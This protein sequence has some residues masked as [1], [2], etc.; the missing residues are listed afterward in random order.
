VTTVTAPQTIGALRRAVAAKLVEAFAAAGRHGTPALDAKVLTAHALGSDSS[1]IVLLDV[2]P[3]GEGLRECL[4]RLVARRIAGEP[5]ARIVGRKEFW[6][7][8]L[9]LSPETLVPR[10]DTETLVTAALE[11]IDRAGRRNDRLAILDLGTGTGA[12]L[13]ALLS[14]LPSAHGIG[15]DRAA[16]AV[17]MARHNAARLGF[18]ERATFAVMDWGKALAGGFDAILANPPYIEA[19]AI[20]K[21]PVEVC[22]DPLLALDGGSDG[23]DAYRAILAD[24]DRLLAGNGHA[25]LEVGA[26]QATM[27]SAIAARHGF[28]ARRHLDL[29]GI[30][31]VVELVRGSD[32]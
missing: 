5:V 26:G 17:A 13:L 18:A 9:A 12:I 24:L 11:A 4:F 22:H 15:T 27:V 20:A 23:M 28:N 7:L 1:A 10:P 19:D 14:E 16:G 6:G 25:Y 3:A 2:S 21:L 29:A 30:D 32:G 8:D 31:R